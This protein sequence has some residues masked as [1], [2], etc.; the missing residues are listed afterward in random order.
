MSSS[1]RL[2]PPAFVEPP[3]GLTYVATSEPRRRVAVKS[4]RVADLA[5]AWFE[6]HLKPALSTR[7]AS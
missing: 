2:S 5:G 3:N 1:L 6:R 4:H 7:S